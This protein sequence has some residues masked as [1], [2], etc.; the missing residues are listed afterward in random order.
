MFRQALTLLGIAVLLAGC[1]TLSL[2]GSGPMKLSSDAQRIV[3]HALKESSTAYVAVSA[4]GKYAGYSYCPVGLG[5]QCTGNDGTVVAINACE[6]RSRGRKCYIYAHGG[7]VVWDFDGPAR[8]LTSAQPDWKTFILS[9]AGDQPNVVIPVVWNAETASGRLVSGGNGAGIR[10]C[11]GTFSTAPGVTGKW[12]LT[13]AGGI[14]YAGSIAKQDSLR[15]FGT[16][17]T[18]T[19]D[20][21]RIVI[22]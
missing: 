22:E 15:L 14:A 13:C 21:V 9:P 5:I 17:T 3:A 12:Q 7:R 1:Q 6:S 20:D 11:K 4:D 18:A 10:D 19:G 2:Y 16:G 8:E